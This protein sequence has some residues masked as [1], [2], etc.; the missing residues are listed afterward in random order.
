MREAFDTHA[1]QRRTA[2]IFYSDDDERDDLGFRLLYFF[3][4]AEDASAGRFLP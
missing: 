2:Q 4:T 3:E 1:I